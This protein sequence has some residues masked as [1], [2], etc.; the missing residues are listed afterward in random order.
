MFDKKMPLII[1][2]VLA[3]SYLLNESL[4]YSQNNF[5]VNEH[6]Y[7]HKQNFLHSYAGGIESIVSRSLLARNR[8]V[9]NKNLGH[10]L[11]FSNNPELL[12]EISFE[13]KI[14]ENGYL[15][16]I[17][18]FDGV[19]FDGFR[20]SNSP[21]YPNIFYKSKL[22]GEFISSTQYS[23]VN[24]NDNVHTATLKSISNKVTLLVDGR[25]VLTSN[26]SF[27]LNHFGFYT[28]LQNIEIFNVLAITQTN[29]IINMGFSSSQQKGI[30]LLKNIA[31]VSILI[32]VASGLFFLIH[33]K[34]FLNFALQCSLFIFLVSAFWLAFDYNYY[35]DIHQVW[36]YQSFSYKTLGSPI[37]DLEQL[38]YR[39]FKKWN[40]LVGGIEINKKRLNERG[41]H[42]NHI[43]DVRTCSSSNHC[44]NIKQV[45]PARSEKVKRLLY[46]GASFSANAGI[47][48][49]EHSFF[50]N[51]SKNIIHNLKKKNIEIETFNLSYPG[52]R[53]ENKI[54]ELKNK[55]ND[56]DPN[57]VIFCFYVE[58]FEQNIFKDFVH[59]LSTK[60]ITP[61]Y[62][63][64]II[65]PELIKIPPGKTLTSRLLLGPELIS[66]NELFL[67]MKDK[68]YFLN[69]NQIALD[70]N[71][72]SKGILWWDMG[73]MTPFGQ[74]LLSNELSKN[75][76]N[77]LTRK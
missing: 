77:I 30:L 15:D 75:I 13:F 67:D 34:N 54:K 47:T 69:S 18:N 43:L 65:N 3:G 22:T 2:L 46:I 24:F 6:W 44:L 68:V 19:S 58:Q 36:D 52:I 4:I 49:F 71:F 42:Y 74:E 61:I 48:S 66:L 45:P 51:F 29:K 23:K 31:L 33:K 32:F 21:L 53:F 9:A 5:F 25:N 73:H 59:Y 16:L 20:L 17:Y 64:P 26:N 10:Q 28:S 35:S 12:K 72:A 63:F 1:L 7:S 38:R 40:K 50:D 39:F 11:I 70:L 14:K 62:I 60:N 76:E 37:I 8:L 56:Y 55:I 41:I 27:T 57:Y